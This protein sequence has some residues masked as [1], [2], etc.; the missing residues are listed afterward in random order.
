MTWNWQLATNQA[1]HVHSQD[2]RIL[3]DLYIYLFFLEGGD[4]SL[5]PP[6]S[7]IVIKGVIWIELGD[8]QVPHRL[9]NRRPG[10]TPN[11]AQ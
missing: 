1:K 2:L 9:H 11:H 5:F 4:E 10:Q 3:F 6:M 8:A 7:I